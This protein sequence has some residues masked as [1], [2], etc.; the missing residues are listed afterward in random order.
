MRVAGYLTLTGQAGAVVA[1]GRGGELDFA[2][3]VSLKTAQ[4]GADQGASYTVSA[5]GN[6][7]LSQG[8]LGAG[9]SASGLGGQLA[10]HGA[11]VLIDTAV[12]L[13]SGSFRATATAPDGKLTL[14]ADAS[15]DVS[16]RAFDFED[17]VR[18]APGG[19]ISL[20]ASGDQGTLVIDAKA[21]LNASGADRGGDA[22]RVQLTAGGGASID[23]RILGTAAAGFA[24]G[25]FSIDAASVS[26]DLAAF[27]QRLSGFDLSH[28]TPEA[29]HRRRWRPDADR[30]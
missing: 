2:G 18:F 20:A 22:G 9:S 26:A 14:G 25:A 15:I 27:M 11:S 7:A 5:A 3:D 8:P 28:S 17:Q 6:L 4:L 1:Q 23:G 12:L 21:M 24:G 10:L 30:P 16:G 29:G 19:S 13:P